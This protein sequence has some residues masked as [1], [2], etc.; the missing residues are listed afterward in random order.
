[1]FVKLLEN[2]NETHPFWEEAPHHLSSSFRHNSRHRKSRRR[3]YP[4]TFFNRRLQ[5]RQRLRLLEG[6]GVRDLAPCS[7][8]VQLLSQ[9]PHRRRIPAEIGQNRAQRNRSG[10]R[11]APTFAA[12]DFKM[13]LSLILFSFSASKNFE[14]KSLVRHLGCS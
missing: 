4:Q 1:M 11:S 14:I 6:Y 12:I 8:L 2:E 7:R 3:M 5:V 9:F 10:V 13:S